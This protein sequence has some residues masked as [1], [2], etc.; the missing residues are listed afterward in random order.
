MP[1]NDLGRRLRQA[2]P[3]V[4]SLLIILPLWIL[5]FAGDFAPPRAALESRLAPPQVG[6]PD[7]VV[8]GATLEAGRGIMGGAWVTIFG[9]DLAPK[10]RAWTAADFAG[11]RAP[12]SLEGVSV[13]INGKPAFVAFL[14]RGRDFGLSYDQINLLAPRD[15]A[16][17]PVPV[18]VVTPEGAS[19]PVMVNKT[20]LAPA[21]FAFDP[22]GRKYLAAATA[23]G[24]E[25]IGKFNLFGSKH[26]DRPIRP[27]RSGEVV[28]LYGNGF[29]ATEPSIP[30]GV[31]ARAAAPLSV[32][33]V[34]RFGTEEAQIVYAGAAPTL[35]GVYQFNVRVPA[36]SPGEVE[37]TAEIAGV[38][39][40]AGRFLVTAEA[41]YPTFEHGK[42]SDFR[43]TGAHVFVECTKC[44]VRGRFL[45]T[46]TAC[47]A[48]HLAAYEQTTN[49]NHAASNF[50]K[51]CGGCH[52]T[53]QFPGAASHQAARFQLSGAHASLQCSRC[54]SGGQFTGLDPACAS[55]HLARYNATT[56]PNHA[57]AGLPRD[58]ALCH[59]TTTF[60]GARIDHLKFTLAGAHASLPCS[61]CHAGGQYAGLRADCASCHLARYNA[62]TSPNH[63]AAGYPTTCSV[64]HSTT[65]FKGAVFAHARFTLTGAHQRAQCSACHAGGRY[66]GT[67]SACAACHL[68]RYN[69]TVNPSHAAAGFP[70]DCSLCHSTTQFTGARF[71]HARFSL[72]GAHA[73]LDCSRCHVSQRYAGTPS[74]CASCHLARYNATAS[75]NHAAAGFP[76]DCALCHTTTQFRGA[77]FTH[78]RF[79]I[80]SG[81]HAGKWPECSAC[82]VNP[83]NFREF[84]CLGCHEKSRTDSNHREVR[85][86]VYESASCYA[87]HPGGEE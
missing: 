66:A 55:C 59:N 61:S 28:T 23:D 5:A 20:A 42:F 74:D 37:V 85:G 14:L 79:P 30:D 76:R 67:P 46:P 44:H 86:Y 50:P 26:L 31:I 70:T 48:C 77:V 27:A 63:V 38:R 10:T 43:L 45:G 12:T 62:T 80:Y 25:Y 57:A 19:P 52:T 18:E 69:A 6:S 24:V 13:R 65:S 60:A 29:G 21:F 35:V 82:H 1:G 51:D 7:R 17:G 58:C 73:T 87:C 53:S 47:A 75:P 83:A 3:P 81:A 34:I 68:S 39:T 2:R 84:S 9:T 64:C 4:A 33:P 40:P 78:S 54:H 15:D 71:L 8:D 11:D 22:E 16:L 56:N 49:P 36:L 32:P 41:P 72:T